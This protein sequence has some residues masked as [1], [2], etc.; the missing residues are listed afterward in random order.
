MATTER[1]PATNRM[2]ESVPQNQS[3]AGGSLSSGDIIGDFTLES[4]LSAHSGE[5]EIYLASQGTQN[6]IFKYYYPNF[7]P[8]DDL[9]KKLKSFDHPDV[10]KLLDYG[11]HNG[12]F[13]EVQDYAAGGSLDD[14]NSDGTWKYLPLVLDRLEGVVSEIINGFKAIHDAGIIH[15][16]IKPSNFYWRNADG[17]DLVIGDF[18]ISSELDLDGGM[19]K[20]MTK[21]SSMTY[22][23]GAP[24]VFSSVIGK[25]M[26]YYALGP[27]IYELFTGKTMLFDE[28]TGKNR[29]ERHLLRDTIQGRMCDDLLSRPESQIFNERMKTLIRGLMTVRH[30]KR[31]G[32][33]EV[34]RWLKGETVPVDTA[35]PMA[36]SFQFKTGVE[37][38][39]LEELAKAI[40]ADRVMGAKHFYRGTIEE[41]VKSQNQAAYISI[42]D[43]R[44]EAQKTKREKSGV[45]WLLYLLD[46]DLPCV[47]ENGTEIQSIETLKQLLLEAPGL[48]V[49]DLRNNDSPIHSMLRGRDAGILSLSIVEISQRVSL[50]KKFTNLVYLALNGNKIKPFEKTKWAGTELVLLDHLMNIPEA[51]KP[52][53][54]MELEESTSLLS[55]WVELV[56]G[57]GTELFS[58][59]RAHTWE[60]LHVIIYSDHGTAPARDKNN[61]KTPKLKIGDT[62]AGGIVFYLDENGGGLVAAT[63]DQRKN[64]TWDDA[65]ALCDNLVSNGFND[66]RMPTKEELNLMYINLKKKKRGGIWSDWYWNSSESHDNGAWGQDFGNGD[67]GNDY[68]N[69]RNCVRAIRAF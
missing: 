37:V 39:T 65:K 68:K 11:T 28:K 15:R 36:E 40:Q 56:S 63:V 64:V 53:V 46:P 55:A 67:L 54:L 61:P 10:V 52:M 25:E 62:F 14:K 22:G 48:V 57:K 18:G 24:E 47:L 51:L 33:S 60:L 50:Q 44:E 59:G 42:Y 7:K 69:G 8:K 45:E 35:R 34:S 1:I 9:L 6:V 20:V 31:W 26:D 29:D 19:S 41:W 30:D 16:D 2:P 49:A 58:G 13:Y 27:V 3:V 38:Q 32:Y 4:M 23:Y 43:L 5:A 17:T 21:S 12:R 66:W